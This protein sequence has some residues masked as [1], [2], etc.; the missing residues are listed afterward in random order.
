VTKKV[1]AE[2][3]FAQLKTG[4]EKLPAEDRARL[5][6]MIF[7]DPDLSSEVGFRLMMF[8]AAYKG[9]RQK[10]SRRSRPQDTA[11][12][13]QIL[14]LRA[15]GLSYG[16]IAKRLRLTPDSVRSVCRRLSPTA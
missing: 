12:N 6:E 10:N 4:F 2:S 11:R 9:E 16:V 8:G 15:T 5:R 1:T 13:K 7:A 3:L 14:D